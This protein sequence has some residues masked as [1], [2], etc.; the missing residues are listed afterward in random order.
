MRS[1]QRAVVFPERIEGD[2]RDH[3]LL[4]T[5]RRRPA[6]SDGGADLDA[7]DR[8]AV[9][10]RKARGH[11]MTEPSRFQNQNGS[12]DV[13]RTALHGQAEMLEKFP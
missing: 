8:A 9:V 4:A 5:E 7:V 2:V 1:G 3:H 6:R 10:L 11:R 12:A 13:R